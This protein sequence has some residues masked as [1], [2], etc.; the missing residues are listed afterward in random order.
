[1]AHHGYNLI[2]VIIVTA[3]ILGIVDLFQGFIPTLLWLVLFGIYVV[4]QIQPSYLFYAFAFKHLRF[5]DVKQLRLLLWLQERLFNVYRFV[6]EAN[7]WLQ[8]QLEIVDAWFLD[9]NRIVEDSVSFR[10]FKQFSG[11]LVRGFFYFWI[12]SL[13]FNWPVGVKPP[14]NFL[15]FRFL[16]F[17]VLSHYWLDFLCGHDSIL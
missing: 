17:L 3:Q 4:G 16:A 8:F 13:D 6:L 15:N 7:L 9:L 14:L 1:M 12:W 2:G 10:P 5:G 11:L